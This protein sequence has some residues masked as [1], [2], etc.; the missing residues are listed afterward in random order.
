M[1][2]ASFFALLLALAMLVG[3]TP[4][5]QPDAGQAK[6]SVVVVLSTEAEPAA[7]F[8]PAYGWGAGEHVHEPLI[9][10]TLTV[11]NAD[12]TIGYDL[13]TDM[14]VSDDGLTWTVTIR[15]GVTF[16]D[17]EALTAQDVAFTYNT[18][19]AA[20]S[21]SDFTMLDYAEATDDSTVVFHMVH[22]YSIW[23]Y[24]MAITGILPEHAYDAATYGQAP[25]GSGRYLLKQWDKGQQ[26]ILEANPN[27]YGKAP[28]MQKVTILFMAEDAAY[29]AAKSAQADV[30]YTAASYAATIPD[31]C[32]LLS[33]QTV[34]NR[35]VNLPGF[36]L[37]VRQAINVGID[38]NALVTNVLD[39]Y[40]TPAYTVCDGM[41][42][43]PDGVEIT[44]DLTAAA[45]LLD[46]DGWLLGADGVRAKDGKALKINFLYPTGDSVRQA[47]AAEL[48][49]QLSTLGFRASY[50]AVG[51]DTAYDRA[52]TEPLVWGWGSHTPME[53]YNIYSDSSHEV[54]D[55]LEQAMSSTALE[56]SY[57]LWQQA[58]KADQST[59]A[60]L[61]NVNHLFLVRDGLTVAEQK[62]HPH[63]HGWS[64]VN[65]VDAWS[66]A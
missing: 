60:W 25:I 20:T 27:Y 51:W 39:G 65:N 63:G 14:T 3:C 28:S 59:W 4:A 18:V 33:V 62:L 11:T 53:V 34:D 12:L 66:W 5:A 26:V 48:T 13:A 44:H 49:N 42:W 40:G 43:C 52:E 54:A 47:L 1:R 35:G 50:E 16:S 23:P 56:A 37:A 8:D 41:P 30:S 19:K 22:P 32:S 58:Q 38:R 7:G 45:A 57:P 10:S 31:A 21:V 9:Q 36:E 64:I 2:K 46:G 61:V 6:D 55:L 15:N 29:L 17:G 24:T